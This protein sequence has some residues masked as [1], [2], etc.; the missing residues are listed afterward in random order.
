MHTQCS[1]GA[2]FY[3]VGHDF[4]TMLLAEVYSQLFIVKCILLT[5]VTYELHLT[6]SFH[7]STSVMPYSALMLLKGQSILRE[8]SKQ[9]IPSDRMHLSHS[10]TTAKNSILFSQPY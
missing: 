3:Y 6:I 1:D 4:E 10:L 5:N 8:D 7:I 2:T 9:S